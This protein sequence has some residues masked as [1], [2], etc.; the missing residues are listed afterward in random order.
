MPHVIKT[1]VRHT[2]LNTNDLVILHIR[3]FASLPEG[4]ASL[5]SYV[6]ILITFGTRLK[7]ELDADGYSSTAQITSDFT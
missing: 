6:W 1:P 2:R 5:F 4:L 7:S 3:F